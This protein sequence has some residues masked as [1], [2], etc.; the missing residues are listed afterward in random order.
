VHLIRTCKTVKR[1]GLVLLTFL[2]MAML[3]ILVLVCSF[4]TTPDLRAC[5][6]TNAGDVMQVPEETGNPAT[7][8]MHG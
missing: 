4:S 6:Q 8:F 3:A 1:F 7:C 5:D 2:R